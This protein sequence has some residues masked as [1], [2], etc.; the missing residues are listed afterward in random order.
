L[1]FDEPFSTEPAAM[2]V[3]KGDL[4]ILNFLSSWITINQANGWLEQR[5]QYW[6]DTLEWR[7][8][9]ATDPE[10]IKACEESF[11]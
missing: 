6:F 10:T 11:Q 7:D 9:V 3:R 2:A 8:Q 1:P 4:D 5:R